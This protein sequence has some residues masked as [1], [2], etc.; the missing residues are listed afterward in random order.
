MRPVFLDVPIHLFTQMLFEHC[1]VLSFTWNFVC[2]WFIL[3]LSC[4][5]A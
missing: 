3:T 2:P 1:L 4:V 5:Q